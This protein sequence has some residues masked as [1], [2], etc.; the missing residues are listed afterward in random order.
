MTDKETET[1]V[2]I[3]MEKVARQIG[4]SRGWSTYNNADI[5]RC[6]DAVLA[7]V[8]DNTKT[9]QLVGSMPNLVAMVLTAALYPK[10]PK[11]EYGAYMGQRDVVFYLEDA[12][13]AT[14]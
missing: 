8:N 5:E 12:V 3:E 6:I 9:V 13:E 10:I 2:Y 4:L 14:P 7:R 11:L 1:T